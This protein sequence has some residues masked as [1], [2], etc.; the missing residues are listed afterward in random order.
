MKR[1]EIKQRIER[2]KYGTRGS[3]TWRSFKET[4]YPSSKQADELRKKRL[5]LDIDP[6]IRPLVLN[7]NKQGIK[8]YGSCAGHQDRGY[9]V[10]G[11]LNEKKEKEVRDIL[12]EEGLNKLRGSKSKDGSFAVT[13]DPIGRNSKSYNPIK[14]RNSRAR[15]KRL[16]DKAQKGMR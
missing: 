2:S 9:L 11:H 3:S 12:K 10:F 7:L 5:P 16:R 8:T 4:R 1:I 14:A 6:E 13:Y 15:V